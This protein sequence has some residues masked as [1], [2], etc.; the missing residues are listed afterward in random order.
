MSAEPNR[1]DEIPLPPRPP[2]ALPEPANLPRPTV[3]VTPFAGRPRLPE[4]GLRVLPL[5]SFVWGGPA[6]AG[7]LR[8]GR[9]RGDHCLVRV[10]AGTLRIVLPSGAVDHGP[11]SVVFIPAGTAF[12]A[13]PQPGVAGQALLMPH[14]M[15]ERLSLPNRIVVGAGMSDAFSADLAALAARTHDPIAAATAACRV[16]LI[17]ASLERVAARPEPVRTDLP[18]RDSHALFQA[19]IELAGREMGRGRTLADLAEALGTTAA[20]LDG[21]CRRHRGCS[22]LDLIY[23]LRLERAR[24]LL[25]NPRRSLAQIAEELGFTGPAH[26]NRVFMAATGKPAEAFR[27]QG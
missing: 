9:T 13:E 2:E 1:L 27:P 7:G 8:R 15:A 16:E 25:A 20:G 26:M 19:Y 21:A 4:N 5:D 24:T 3:P 14:H 23:E 11:G 18:G 17:A 12:A 6:L 10:T 22:A